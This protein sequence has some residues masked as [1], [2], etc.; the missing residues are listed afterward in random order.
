MAALG[1]WTFS[2]D[3]NGASQQLNH[4]NAFDIDAWGTWGSGTLTVQYSPDNGTTWITVSGVSL[5]ANGSATM[6][7][8]PGDLFRPV[9]A[10]A[11][12]PSLTVKL[13]ETV[14]A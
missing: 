1:E 13:R 11:T 5:T 8:V 3:G 14:T 12:N 10:G 6:G 7:G 4:R 9:L 2:A